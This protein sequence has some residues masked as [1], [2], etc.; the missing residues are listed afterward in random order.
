MKLNAIQCLRALAVVLVVYVHS[1]DLQMTF[2]K[3]IQ[4]DL[5]YLQNFGAIGVDLFFVISGFIITYIANEYRGWKDAKHFL[6]KRF[7]RINPV[8]YV[9]SCLFLSINLIYFL[10]INRNI[11]IGRTIESLCDTLFV[12]P[13]A[14]DPREFGPILII[15]WTLCFEWIFYIMFCFFIIIKSRYKLTQLILLVILL[16]VIGRCFKISDYR[17]LFATNPILLEFL[18]GMVIC[19]WYQNR[20][21][22][23]T[24]SIVL[25]MSGIMGYI[26]LVIFGY[27]QISEAGNILSGILSLKRV[28]LWGGPSSLLVAGSVFMER[29]GLLRYAWTNRYLQVIGDASFSIY[30][31]HMSVI[32]MIRLCYERFGFFLDPDL[33]VFVHLTFGVLLSVLFYKWIERPLLGKLQKSFFTKG[34]SLLAS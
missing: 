16:V 7:I 10:I 17:V 15:G 19:W 23:K 11:D 2:S 34:H 14:K 4:Q 24:L 30:L 26:C 3:S 12:V 27:G 8:Y 5:F 18:L 9:A 13:V 25:F 20:N 22:G 29:N 33:S 6:A 1:I 21:V 32:F 28:L 31:V